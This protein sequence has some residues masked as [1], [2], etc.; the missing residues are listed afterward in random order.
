MPI[1]RTA[2]VLICVAVVT[3]TSITFSAFP[4]FLSPMEREF[5]WSRATVTLPF[6]VNM[7]GWAVGAVLFGKLA[8]DFG[9][10]GVILGG[11]VPMA[12]GYLGMGLSQNLWQVMLS[13]GVL[14]GLAMGA[15]GL[16]IVSLLVSKHFD[17]GGRGFAVGMIQTAPSFSALLFAPVF[18]FLIQTFEWRTAALAAGGMLGVVA[19]PL[20]LP[21]MKIAARAGELACRTAGTARCSCF[22]LRVCPAEWRFSKLPIW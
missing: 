10:R 11:I 18:F 16:S 13:F 1:S 20:A 5:G 17:A 7:I 15:C 14:A 2:M 12:A 4:L 6:V 21:A 9:A 3:M 8:D 22:S 19:L